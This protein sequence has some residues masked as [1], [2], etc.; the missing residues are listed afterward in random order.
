MAGK[1]AI[2]AIRVLSDARQGRQGLDDT[3]KS[4]KQLEDALERTGRAAT[5]GA[6]ATLAGIT[7][8]A[9]QWGKAASDAQ[10]AA[11]AMESVYGGYADAIEAASSTSAQAVGLAKR[12]YQQ[13]ASV[14]GAQLKNMGVPMDRVAGQATD[15]IA[16][17]ADLSAM[18]GG[19]TADAV[20]ALSSLLRGERDPIERYGVSIKQ[21]SIDAYEAAH[22][23]DGLTGAAKT[24]ADTQATLALLTEQTSAAQ[25]QF[26][27]EGDTA[28]GAAQRASAAYEDASA[29]LGEAL[30]PYMAEGARIAADLAGGLSDNAETIMPLLGLLAGLAG[31]VLLVQGAIKA[32][33]AAAVVATVAQWAWNVAMNANPIGLLIT[34][35]GLLIAGIILI[36][37]HW[38]EASSAAQNF[39]AG[40]VEWI[41]PAIDAISDFIGWIWQGVQAI[42]QLFGSAPGD[43]FTDPGM[44]A[45]HVGVDYGTYGSTAPLADSL[46]VGQWDELGKPAF[47][48]RV[49]GSS[50]APAGDTYNVSISGALDPVAVGR[51]VDQA[52]GRYRRTTGA[53]VAAGR[54]W[55]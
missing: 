21:A 29:K 20:D 3:R 36:A 30:L 8:L 23:L 17:G 33:E 48:G 50:A 9:A 41:Q 22:G 31:G 42:G 40:F 26:A 4:A 15:L 16:L 19:T 6:T 10:Q 38:D 54:R 45:M 37:T 25:G 11:G 7:L 24:Q 39:A 14:L 5:V 44:L 32:Y 2:L 13:M 49:G 55:A 43:L 34:A 35:A 27:R 47:F 52:I 1:T 12:D 53:N 18:F 28:A 51:Q 46:T